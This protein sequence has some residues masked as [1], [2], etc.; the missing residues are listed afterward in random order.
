MIF[1]L[2]KAVFILSHHKYS[3]EGEK[4]YIL[5][6]YKIK[7]GV[8]QFSKITLNT[9]LYINFMVKSFF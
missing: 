7:N 2:P 8:N 4:K 1:L 3:K 6:F 9:D 5:T